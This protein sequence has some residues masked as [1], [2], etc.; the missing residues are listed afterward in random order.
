VLACPPPPITL[1]VLGPV[2]AKSAF[3]GSPK[4]HKNGRARGAENETSSRP[5]GAKFSVTRFPVR[6]IIDGEVSKE[7]AKPQDFL[8]K[9]GKKVSLS[10][11]EH[12]NL[13]ISPM[14][15]RSAKSFRPEKRTSYNEALVEWTQA[16][17]QVGSPSSR[18]C[19]TCVHVAHVSLCMLFY[20]TVC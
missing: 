7:G 15:L 20:I 11:Y 8:L 6:E 3:S 19:K 12:N 4:A 16:F 18:T 1:Q 9:N 17:M 5:Q 13:S 10:V 2:P 14:S